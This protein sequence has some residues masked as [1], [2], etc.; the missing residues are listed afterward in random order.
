[1]LE[2]ILVIV[3]ANIL[4]IVLV[5]GFIRWLRHRATGGLLQVEE[6]LLQY[7]DRLRGVLRFLDRYQEAQEDPYLIP[8]QQIS[9]DLHNLAVRLQAL[10]ETGESL[11]NEMTPGSGN[12]LQSIINAPFNWISRWRRAKEMLDESATLDASMA[13][14]EQAASAVDEIPWQVALQ[15]R[16][17]RVDVAEMARMAQSLQ[18][19]GAYG[20]PLQAST[21]TIPSMQR[22]LGEVA[23]KFIEAG[24][25]ELLASASY[26]ETIAAHRVLDAVSPN[27][28]RWLP[29]LKEWDQNQQKAQSEFASI[30][31]AIA[32]LRRAV[33]RPP[34]GLKTGPMQD[35]MNQ[36]MALSAEL[37]ERL[38][39]PDVGQLKNLMREATRLRRLVEDAGQQINQAGERAAALNH[40]IA[41]L[42]TAL[43]AL[44]AQYQ[45]HADQ[46]GYPL[47]L[48]ESSADLNH[49]R[50]ILQTL[51]LPNQDRIPEEI[52]AG[53]EKSNQIRERHQELLEKYQK[54]VEQ[55]QAL[56]ALLKSTELQE[57]GAWI[58]KTREW[59]G[60]AE[61]YDPR[62]WPKQEALEGIKADLTGLAALQDRVVPAGQSAPVKESWL[63][64]RLQEAQQLAGLHK[65]LRPRVANAHARLEKIQA[66]EKEGKDLLSS[67][68]NALERVSI[69]SDSNEVL[70]KA[71]GADIQRQTNELKRLG[72]ELNARNQGLIEK[73]LQLIQA[74]VQV[75]FQSIQAWM[76][77]LDAENQALAR[78]I[79]DRLAELDNIASLEDTHFQEAR[80]LVS[81]PELRARPNPTG[82]L[83]RPIIA[84]RL[85]SE[86]DL[87]DG[88]FSGELK[89]KND[90]WLSLLSARQALD[91]KNA[92]LLQAYHDTL[93]A[94]AQAES[95]VGDVAA[96]Q[97]QRR[98]WP[99]TN[100]PPLP[101]DQGLAPID[102]RW[103]AMRKQRVRS[104]WA[105]L[106]L[107]RLAGQYRS[108]G[109][110][111]NN[112]LERITQDQEQI[113]DMEEELENLKQRWL[114]Q[115][116]AAPDHPI[117][118]Q[119][120]QQL[121]NQT[122]SKLS[123]IRQQYM[124]GALSYSDV[125]QSL[126]LLV[127]ETLKARVPYDENR[128]ISL[129]NQR[130]RL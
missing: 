125:Q 93:E 126:N 40:A 30:R 60:Q 121:I 108:L 119:G 79:G 77:R 28:Q 83:R 8:L 116:Q 101:P 106:E 36:V 57:G 84:K 45:S 47:V 69:L 59:I 85:P 71:A 49:L 42:K 114:Q 50:Q 103:D 22:S 78:Q 102:A 56:V 19:H 90:L 12:Q 9:Q 4:L 75:V 109:E 124:R 70:S 112:L 120:V 94:R 111:A 33:A 27:I 34:S 117:L 44:A 25:N 58:L 63:G 6:H 100:Q 13:E 53:L 54:I 76:A 104:D 96:R 67:A 32:D 29:A 86:Q 110:R 1:M 18:Q 91:E 68:W 21:A 3:L 97:A 74:Q 115:A 65:S 20:S 88:V 128:D 61:M 14:I 73:K 35:R 48:D 2:I 92:A 26:R 15:I 98:G 113:I 43:D 24:Q 72:D 17:A 39:Q 23:P 31:L 51:G 46:A 80:Q 16:Q 10:D 7:D 62:H 41:E 55:Y 130:P 37:E 82:P 123:F 52:A 107:G 66:L 89:R 5:V 118:F 11:R 129:P 81:I 105:M 127:D 122:D 38:T 99:P 64:G 87:S 95:V